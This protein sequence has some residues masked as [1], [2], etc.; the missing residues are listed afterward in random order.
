MRRTHLLSSS[1]ASHLLV[2]SLAS[3]CAGGTSDDAG[4]TGPADHRALIPTAPAEGLG[5]QF[6][7][8]DLVIPVGEERM[9][10]WVPDWVPDRDYLVT[11][12]EGVQ[13]PLGHHVV[14]LRSGIAREPGTVFDCTN[15]ASMVS[16]EPLVL[17]DP[18]EETRL[19]PE[20]FAVRLPAGSRIVIQSHYVNYTDEDI[21]TADVARFTFVPL[22]DEGSITEVSYLIANHGALIVDEGVTTK[23]I[24][25]ALPSDVNVLA[26]LGHMHGLGKEISVTRTPASGIPETLY[27]VPAWTVEFR[28]VPPLELFP[29]SAPLSLLAGDQLTVSC[30]YDNNTGA[31]VGF[32]EEMCTSVGYYFP[33]RPEGIIFCDDVVE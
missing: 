11:R 27:D 25:C 33:A 19:L 31:V 29:A 16:L 22:E 24:G 4:V 5:R 7:A 15:L 23:K 13:S 26:L 9:T 3:A 1:F 10:C 20:G 28:D 21:V 12:F 8:P 14:A 18:T 6:V 2:V 30:T 17:P 32:P